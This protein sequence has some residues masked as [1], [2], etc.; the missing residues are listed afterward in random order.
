V[1]YTALAKQAGAV[2]SQPAAGSGSSEDELIRSYGFDPAVIKQSP[3]YQQ[4]VKR[5]GSGITPLL[6]D[7]SRKDLVARLADSPLGDL[8][9]G[10]LDVLKGASQLSTHLFNK[11]GVV[12]DAD[13]AYLDLISKVQERDYLENVRHG[14][15][16][17]LARLAGNVAVPVPGGGLIRGEGVATNLGRAAV[18]GAAAAATQP[19]EGGE[20]YWRQKGAQVATGA[21]VGAGT[22]GATAVIGKGVAKAVNARAGRIPKEAADVMAAGEKWGVPV[23]PGDLTGNPHAQDMEVL[24]ERVPIIGTSNIRRVGQEKARAGVGKL[25]S[26][27]RAAVDQTKFSGADDLAKAAAAGDA[28]AA[29]VLDLMKNAGKDPDKLLKASL[30]LTDYQTSRVAS[31]LYDKV[32][33][34]AEKHNLGNVPLNTTQAVIDDV[35]GKAQAAKKPDAPL[36]RLLKAVKSNIAPGETVD[37]SYG[38]IR[39]LRSDLGT[40]IRQKHAGDNAL[41]GEKGVEQLQQLKG[42][43]EADLGVFAQ[44]SGVPEL[45]K[46]AKAADEYYRAARVP[47]KDMMIAKSSNGD[48]PDLIFNRFVQPGKGDRAQK[49]YSALDDKGRAAVRSMIVDRAVRDATTEAGSRTVFSPQ[50]FSTAMENMQDASGVFFKGT[51]KFEVDGFKNLMD[52]VVRVGRYAENPPT[53][54]RLVPIV[55][56]GGTAGLGY[57]NPV[58]GVGAAALLTMAKP[59]MMSAAGKK[60]LLAASSLKPGSPAMQKLLDSIPAAVAK[61]GTRPAEQ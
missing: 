45:E 33:G 3:H 24:L 43:V 27:F 46:A 26:S 61:A 16:N 13:T 2:S 6:T 48:E 28:R 57:I 34:I 58:A 8:G 22:A 41:I 30:N 10:A 14:K 12:S 39:D 18:T 31:G 37:N 11:L 40:I 9:Q 54:N 55:L 17:G 32:E 42:A 1:D 44:N 38:L 15:S 52:H 7:P 20:G 21:A 4:A 35:L 51:D 49:F 25:G 56:A 5:W 60:F 36:I 19:A 50:K 23:T 47:Y 29:E 53:G 59:L